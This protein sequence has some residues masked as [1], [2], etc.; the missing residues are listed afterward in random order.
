MYLYL[1]SEGRENGLWSS[2]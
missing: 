1:L 2:L